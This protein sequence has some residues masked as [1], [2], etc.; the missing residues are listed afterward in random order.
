MIIGF[1]A[2]RLYNNF[3]GLGNYSRTLL[4]NL[5][6]FSTGNQ[7]HLYTPAITSDPET[8]EFIKN[9]YCSTFIPYTLFKSYWRSV[10]VVKQL[11]KDEIQIYHGLSHE[12]PLNINK[13][14]IGTVVTMHDLIFKIYP[15]TYHFIDRQIY[16]SKFRYSCIN[17][18][19]IIAISENTKKDIENLYG[20]DSDKIEVIYQSCNSLF[21]RLNMNEKADEILRKYSIPDDYLL[22]VGSITKRKNIA[23][24]IS[25]FEHLPN[26]LKIPLVI[27]GKG[28]GYKIEVQSLIEKM[29]LSGLVIWIDNLTSNEELSVLY[30]HARIF[31]YPS[32]YEGFG[33]PV[34]E[35]LM[36]K[37]PVITSNVSSLP[38]AGG[39]GSFYIDPVNAEQMAAGIE[40]ILTDANFAEK[41][42]HTGYSY[43]KEKFDAEKNTKK[44]IDLYRKL[45]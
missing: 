10:S 35:A 41:M 22:Y 25:A 2:K 43:A 27:V 1:D 5:L 17:S 31:I 8:E 28:G 7:Y 14:R 21:Y 36:S 6:H 34:I 30:Q 16:D 4:R 24:I 33:I 29:H 3:T 44:L 12:I 11:I 9:P 23:T 26:D 15:E 40:K 32:V 38:E 37:T 20:I 45:I 42:V 18:D 39:P 19:R 13:S